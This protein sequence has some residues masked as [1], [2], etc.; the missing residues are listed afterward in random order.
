[1][2]SPARLTP[3]TP[4]PQAI[5]MLKSAAAPVGI[6]EDGGRAIGMVTMDDLVGPLVGG[7]H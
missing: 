5:A 3:R 2:L 7:E 4:L 6:V 1:V